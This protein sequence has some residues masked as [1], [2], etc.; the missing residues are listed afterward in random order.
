[1]KGGRQTSATPEKSSSAAA[2]LGGLR[3]SPSTAAERRMVT[4]GQAKMMHSASGTGISVKL[5]VAQTSMSPAAR[6][7]S[8]TRSLHSRAWPG[9]LTLQYDGGLLAR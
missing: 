5:V 8:V 1:M 9:R 6:P 7:A 2:S 3:L 4:T